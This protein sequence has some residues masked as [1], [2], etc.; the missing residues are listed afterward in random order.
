MPK[1]SR[2]L[3][4]QAVSAVTLS[5]AVF[6]TLMAVPRAS[7]RSIAFEDRMF[8]NWSLFVCLLL[9]CWALAILFTRWLA[10][11]KRDRAIAGSS[12]DELL[13]VSSAD[14]SLADRANRA[15]AQFRLAGDAL[16]T[17]DLLRAEAEAAQAQLDSDYV[18]L[19]VFLWAIPVIGLIGTFQGVA[20]AARAF[21]ALMVSGGREIEDIR[22]ALVQAAAS[23]GGAFEVTMAALLMAVVVMAF[24]LLTQQR[25]RA[26]LQ[27]ADDFCRLRLL[28]L[29]L[30]RKV[31]EAPKT[32]DQGAESLELLRRFVEQSS[33]MN[34]AVTEKLQSIETVLAA[35]EE[36]PVNGFVPQA[37]AQQLPPMAQ[38]AAPAPSAFVNT[39]RAE[40]L[41]ASLEELRDSVRALRPFL[42]QV[43]QNLRRQADEAGHPL[44]IRVRV[45][46]KV[47]SVAAA[48]D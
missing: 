27:A 32:I 19:R 29:M 33:V 8:G 39:H 38:S 18:P 16:A 25:E 9:A 4:V 40:E 14:A 17:A 41:R 31:E 11:R 46:P 13:A 15:A 45:E 22:N 21:A 36:P 43:A 23:L 7:A 28:P 48:A 12:V 20:Q 3:A 26:T 42:Q 44:S 1:S 35:R 37:T 2:T 10:A 5:A 24:T 30:P 47:K 34:L 6:L